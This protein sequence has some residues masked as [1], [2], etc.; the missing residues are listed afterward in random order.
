MPSTA[1]ASAPVSSSP[2]A[3]STASRH[4]S[5]RRSATGRSRSAPA[6]RARS[7]ARRDG[8]AERPERV[9]EQ[10]DQAPVAAGPDPHEPPAVPERGAGELLGRGDRAGDVR[11]AGEGVLP[12]G[13]V[14]PAGLCV[15]E[16]EEQL[17]A[18]RLVRVRLER[19]CVQRHL[20]VAGGLL[21]G[22]QV[23][24]PLGGLAR[25]VDGPA[26][27]AGGSGLERVVRELG[28]VRLARGAVDELERLGRAA[29]EPHALP[30]AE[31]AVE[32]VAD[33]R[34]REAQSGA[35]P[36]QIGQHAGGERLVEQVE[37]LVAR[38]P[39]DGF[40][41]VE[42]ELPPEDGRLGQEIAAV[43]REVPQAMGD[44]LAHALREARPPRRAGGFR[45]TP[46]RR[47]QPDELGDE[48]RI[49]LRLVVDR[50]RER[51]VRP[52]AGDELDAP[53]DL[54]PVET[55]ERQQAGDRL[56]AQLGDGL[57]QRTARAR[58]RVA[59]GGDDER[60]GRR[61]ARARGTAAGAGTGASA[62]CR[63]SSDEHA[64]AARRAPPEEAR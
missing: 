11:R 51:V 36:G 2:R 14:P 15:P 57:A 45:E 26:H 31:L 55:A 20:V 32:A 40:E 18:E 60:C 35:A 44:H 19:E 52:C 27:V 28:E 61:A 16:P 58:L 13:G 38:A 53:C 29:M 24:R 64:A 34:V 63:S 22:D 46:L 23:R 62:A 8:R 7:L 54:R 39:A 12:R 50:H 4:S 30:A 5:A 9:L 33:Q 41:H 1:F 47:E 48:E 17:A 37:Q 56:A 43:G 3:S 42:P 25:V 21:V 59:V 49:A 6:S 10:R